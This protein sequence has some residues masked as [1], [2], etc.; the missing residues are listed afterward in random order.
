MLLR[1]LV[2]ALL[3]TGISALVYLLAPLL[4]LHERWVDDAVGSVFLVLGFWLL[5]RAAA[6]ES[7]RQLIIHGALVSVVA[8]LLTVLVPLG[9]PLITLRANASGIHALQWDAATLSL[10]MLRVLALT[11]VLSLQVLLRLKHSV[12]R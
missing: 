12:R 2:E 6:A 11:C 8:F 3:L 9:M 5:L 10:G 1:W 7:A 4:P